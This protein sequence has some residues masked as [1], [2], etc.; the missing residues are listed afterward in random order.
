MKIAWIV[1]PRPPPYRAGLVRQVGKLLREWG[2]R[3]SVLPA[4][5]GALSDAPD[6]D[7]YVIAAEGDA[8][9]A[10]AAD[11]DA[12]GG[13]VLNTYA[14]LAALRQ[15]AVAA[16]RLAA[17]E[18][19]FALG[20][21]ADAKDVP[22]P[23]LTLDGVGGHVFGVVRHPRRRAEEP[24]TLSSDVHRLA[25]RCARALELD[26]FAIDLAVGA[27]APVVVAVRP[28][29]ALRGVPDAALRLADFVYASAERAR[30]GAEA[31]QARVSS[32]A[33]VGAA[34]TR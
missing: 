25:M 15:P 11:V 3:V 29:P 6:H 24:F 1:D 10:A 33:L 2:T 23:T 9:F 12:N 18:V 16:R 13:A 32:G 28:F 30:A 27:G 7:L 8:A 34:P 21:H 20:R 26:L 17:A 31:R 5:G 14:A 4:D 19:P 22:S